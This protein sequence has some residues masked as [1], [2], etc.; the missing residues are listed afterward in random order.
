MT[1]L[2]VGYVVSFIIIVVHVS[3]K[4]RDQKWKNDVLGKT[5]L[6]N[7][8]NAAFLASIPILNSVLV[9]IAFVDLL[10]WVFRWIRIVRYLQGRKNRK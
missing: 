4:L 6:S 8:F 9:I 1:Y 2:I 7:A 10:E 3:I 5:R